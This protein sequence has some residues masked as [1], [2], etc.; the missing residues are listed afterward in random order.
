M[1]H[2]PFSKLE[3]RNTIAQKRLTIMSY[4]EFLNLSSFFWYTTDLKHSE[5]QI[6]NIWSTILSFSLKI[7]FH[8]TKFGNKIKKSSTESSEYYCKKWYYYYFCLKCLNFY[9]KQF[10]CHRRSWSYGAYFLKLYICLHFRGKYQFPG[11]ILT[12]FLT[13]GS[14]ATSTPL[15]KINA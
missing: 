12:G 13:G 2:G 14:F 8:I 5:R 6:P 1:K 10:W 15:L 3:E 11:K 7:T 4:Q 9:K